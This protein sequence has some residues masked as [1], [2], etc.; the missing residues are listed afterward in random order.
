MK[1]FCRS[2]FAFLAFMDI[3]M[4]R[5]QSNAVGNVLAREKEAIKPAI[6]FVRPLLDFRGRLLDF[7]DGIASNSLPETVVASRSRLP[8]QREPVDFGETFFE[9]EPSSNFVSLPVFGQT[10][11]ILKTTQELRD[12]DRNQ[13]S[14][15]DIQGSNAGVLPLAFEIP[16]ALDLFPPLRPAKRLD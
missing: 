11:L 15:I 7:E 4:A 6:L 10:D 3:S 1:T 16:S 12:R 13:E 9:E 5:P 8:A 2:A 14:F